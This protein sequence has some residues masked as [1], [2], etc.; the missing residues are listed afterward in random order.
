MKLLIYTGTSILLVFKDRKV[1]QCMFQNYSSFT[2]GRPLSKV[3]QTRLQSY[4]CRSYEKKHGSSSGRLVVAMA[5]SDVTGNVSS[6][7]RVSYGK[8]GGQCNTQDRV[9]VVSFKVITLVELLASSIMCK[10]EKQG[11]DVVKRL[12]FCHK[13]NETSHLP[14]LPFW[15]DQPLL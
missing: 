5:A 8:T 11:L 15:H 14:F 12:L 7:L 6:H 1:N 2:Q 13:I 3:R 10:D 9:G 4:L